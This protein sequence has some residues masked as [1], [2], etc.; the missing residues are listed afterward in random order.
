MA[1]PQ[2]E[3]IVADGVP[4][5]AGDSDGVVTAGLVFRVGVA[6]E[7][8]LDRGITALIAELAASEVENTSFQVGDTF[9][10]FAVAGSSDDV[11][12]ALAAICSAL[13]H[14]DEQDLLDLADTVARDETPPLSTAEELIEMRYGWE[15]CGVRGLPPLFAYA[16]T[17][18]RAEEWVR[19]R[20]NRGN[21]VAWMTGLA[22]NDLHFPL[23]DGVRHAVPEVGEA[24]CSVG[25]WC[26]QDWIGNTWRDNIDLSTVVPADDALLVAVF[27]FSAELRD[28]LGET[29]L[30][31]HAAEV[32]VD[33]WGDAAHVFMTI[34][35]GPYGDD[36]IEA[37]LGSLDDFIEMGPDAE[38]LTTAQSEVRT[39]AAHRDNVGAISITLARDELRRDEPRTLAQMLDDMHAVTGHDIAE[40]FEEWRAQMILVVPVGCEIIEST[41][42]P[43]DAGWSEPVRGDGYFRELDDAELVVGEDGVSF[44]LDTVELTARYDECVAALEFA[45]GPITLFA[46]DGTAIDVRPE[47]WD[48]GFSALA[49][50][51][52]L[53]PRGIV[54]TTT[55]ESTSRPAPTIVEDENEGA[56]T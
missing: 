18:A 51:R 52:R 4:V 6:D 33:V 38:E 49:E 27:A 12:A 7:A 46:I 13:G 53:V 9:T 34:N 8:P 54:C 21:V 31:E 48:D 16:P 41:L 2:I 11:A 19:E 47:D 42:T 28:R 40:V 23:A 15:F 32:M 3:R 29:H 10:S 36:A 17:L 44:L 22:H 24:L 45:D 50:I 30:R 14:L 25:S 26:A 43:F 1:I 5:Y 20:F 39:W 56:V 37:I 35:V 55:L